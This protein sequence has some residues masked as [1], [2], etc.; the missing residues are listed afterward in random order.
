MARFCLLILCLAAALVSWA[1]PQTPSGT[2]TGLVRDAQRQPAAFAALKL[3]R[4]ADST[5]VTGTVADEAGRYQLSNVPAG[6][7]RL[8]ASL[9]GMTETS[10]S[11]VTVRAGQTTV[12]DTLTLTRDDKTLAAVTVRARRVYIEQ[13]AD[14][15]VLNV[16]ANDVAQS[17]TAFELLQQAPG[18]VVDPNDNI[19]M[20][21]KQDVNVFI[22]GKPA[23]LSASDVANLLRA[24]P[25]SNITTVE[26]ITNPSARFDAQGGA[27]IINIRFR[28]DKSLGLN[29]NAS[30]SYGQSD[31]HRANAALDLNFR[32]RRLN[33]YGNASL[34]DNFQITN[35]ANNRYTGDGRFAQ[36]GY[37]RD[38]TQGVV[39]K[40]GADYFIG[41]HHTLGLV[42][43]GN[44]AANEFGT[45]TTANLFRTGGRPDTSLVNTFDNPTRNN[46]LNAAFNY[47]F[48]DT[49]GHDLNV[50]VDYTRFG[51]QSPNVFLT[52]YM[53]ASGEPL[54]RLRNRFDASTTIGILTIKSDFVRAWKAQHLKLETG[55]KHTDVQTDNAL[56]AF[57]GGIPDVPERPDA[58][59]TNRFAY[60]ETVS[61]AYASLNRSRG[62]WTL[63]AGVRAEHSTVRG[64]STDLAGYV[65]NRPD[66]T[67][68]NLFPTAFVQY[69]L[70][71][72]SQLGLNYGRR[73]GRPNYQDMN[74]F[75]F[76]A[77][78]YTSQRGNPYLRPAYTH[79]AELSY[80]YQWATTLK[81]SY[82][83]TDD[84]ASDVI[85]QNGFV[86]YNTVANVGRADALNMSVSSPLPITKWWDAYVYAG[87]TWTRFQGNLLA[88]GSPDG[89]FD[90]RAFAFDG[91]MQH[92][93]TLSK[94]LSAQVSGFW[95]APTT[96]TIYRNGGLGA[97]NLSLSRKVM[98]ERGKVSLT[99]DDILNTMRWRQAGTFSSGQRFDLDRKWESRRLTLRFSYRFGSD[100]IKA[101]RARETGTDAGRI[102]TKGDL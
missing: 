78:P 3:F 57:T 16:A 90:N 45:Y 87:A 101:A 20:A 93:F 86:G 88:A 67:Y 43:S 55:L 29:G 85:V 99:A 52:D 51:N 60:R 40:A 23:N 92:S 44:A 21:G 89:A 25:A 26:L 100:A 58:S 95:N 66:T 24:T 94:Q 102:K 14:K 91:Y 65:I 4:A 36:R 72:K 56:L 47:H 17:K 37:D 81:A 98:H 63:Q 61:A 76:Q 6:T 7:Y 69:Q 5:L 19:R 75:V 13:Q 49:L 74:P 41:T 59:R 1:Q 12:A 84:W 54:L 27:G 11:I 32:T 64:R 50:D 79:N 97:L 53:N 77:D 68:L 73:I 33:L 30:V 80:T 15:T 83:R 48:T 96:Q 34:S 2:L 10:S 9:V 39:Y 38:R 62:K 42:V 8:R 82:S 70:S 28:R 71:S 35:V 31:H 18:V 46:R 22:D